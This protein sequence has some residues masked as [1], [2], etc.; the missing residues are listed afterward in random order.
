MTVVVNSAE[1]ICNLGLGNLGNYGSISSLTSK[2]PTDKEKVFRKWLPVCRQFVLKLAMPNF[3]LAREIVS[4]SATTP[5]FGYDRQFDK[6]TSCLKVLGIGNAQD[7]QNNYAVEG[8][9]IMTDEEFPDGMPVRYIKDITV[10][11]KYTPE[12][13]L[14][15]AQYLAAYTCMEI[16]Q[17]PQKAGKLKSELP[18]EISISSGL[19]AQENMPIRVSNSRFR[20]SRTSDNPSF[21]NKK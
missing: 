11:S 5:E 14:L 19:N 3:S 12:I 18:Q 9:F 4:E 6:P 2:T 8:D 10:Y 1:E 20:A 15:L 16:T 13:V 17:D 21:T 7:K